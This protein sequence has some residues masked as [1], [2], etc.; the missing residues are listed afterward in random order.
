VAVARSLVFEPDILLL[1]EPFSNLD[2]KLRD[3]MRTDLRILQQ[4]LGITVLF[5]THDQIEALSISDRIVVMDNGHIEQVG[6]PMELYRRPATAVVRDFLGRTVILE[7]SVEEVSS[8]DTVALRLH[9]AGGPLVH[10]RIRAGQNLAKGTA[11]LVAVRPEGID[12][13][14]RE[15]AADSEA[16]DTIN[17]IIDTLLFIGDRFEARVQLPWEQEIF[18]YLPPEDRWRE[19]QTV[20]LQLSPDGIQVWPTSAGVTEFQEVEPAAAP[21]ATEA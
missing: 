4:R 17:G 21:E 8:P 20:S 14:P 3:Q 1:D 13:Q 5:V 9:G 19:G 11:C 6:T 7:G 2:A 15:D 10:A 16:P 18:L 12:V